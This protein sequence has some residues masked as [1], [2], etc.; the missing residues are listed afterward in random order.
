MLKKAFEIK[1]SFRLTAECEL[2]NADLLINLYG[3]NVPHVGGVVTFDHKTRKETTIKF[4]SHDGRIHKD[5]FLAQRL[6][7]YLEKKLPGNLVINAGVHIDGI[8]K[9]QIDDSF[10]MTDEIGKQILNWVNKEA[11]SFKRPV[12]TT[13]LKRDK[14]GHLLG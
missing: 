10:N 6:A 7:Q 2:A 12:Y 13:H 1:K 9:Q 8:T 3:G 4:A 5:I 11:D 14:A